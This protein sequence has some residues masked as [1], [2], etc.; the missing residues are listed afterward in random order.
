MWDYCWSANRIT[1]LVTT[2]INQLQTHI[3][4]NSLPLIAY[5]QT[6]ICSI[7]IL[8]AH[9]LSSTNSSIR[10]GVAVDLLDDIQTSISPFT[11]LYLEPY[12]AWNMA[13]NIHRII[14]W[15]KCVIDA[16]QRTESLPCRLRTRVSVADTRCVVCRRPACKVIQVNTIASH[17]DHSIGRNI[18]QLDSIDYPTDWWTDRL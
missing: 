5:Y 13:Y 8:I 10:A 18:I 17:N 6:T 9:P 12:H 7:Q 1:N 11:A 2:S 14:A 15:F 16:K 3:S 4:G